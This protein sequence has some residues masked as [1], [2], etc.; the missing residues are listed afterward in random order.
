GVAPRGGPGE[1]HR[2]QGVDRRFRFPVRGQARRHASAWLANVPEGLNSSPPPA[3]KWRRSAASRISRLSASYQSA[4]VFGTR[5]PP[6][7]SA[8]DPWYGA[9]SEASVARPSAA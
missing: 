4:V 6:G 9:T 8:S 3:A 1:P 5:L 2:H 7:P